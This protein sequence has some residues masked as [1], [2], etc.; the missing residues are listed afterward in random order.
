MFAVLFFSS[1]RLLILLKIFFFFF[2]IACFFQ[3]PFSFP[4]LFYYL[5][6][7]KCCNRYWKK[8]EK[9]RR[10]DSAW[11][12]EGL[13]TWRPQVPR[14]TELIYYLDWNKSDSL[15]NKLWYTEPPSQTPLRETGSWL[16][17]PMKIIKF[18]SKELNSLRGRLRGSLNKKN[19]PSTSPT[20]AHTA[21]ILLFKAL[22]LSMN[23][24][25][26][27]GLT[28]IWGPKNRKWWQKRHSKE[29]EPIKK[30]KNYN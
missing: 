25:V 6:V 10:L 20:C 28:N 23:V 30:G 15:H 19:P 7:S 8:K 1:L 27:Q 22:F 12:L 11:T 16:I 3:R 5:K 26:R 24:N 4:F 9:R 21:S 14:R 17:S 2:I 13:S 29:T 18:F